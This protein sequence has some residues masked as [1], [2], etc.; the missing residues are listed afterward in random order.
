MVE[1]Q[2]HSSASTASPLIS[3]TA[4]IG[5]L[6]TMWTSTESVSIFNR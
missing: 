1:L 6:T 4:V 3:A 5:L 2:L